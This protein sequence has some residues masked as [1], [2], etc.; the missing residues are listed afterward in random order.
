MAYTPSYDLVPDMLASVDQQEGRIFT[1]HLRPGHRWS[2][3][4]PFTARGFP[5]L[6]G[7]YREQQAVVA[8]RPTGGI[9]ARG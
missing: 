9:A 1:L 6:V 4:A 2:D 5:L 7:R 3:G 8:D